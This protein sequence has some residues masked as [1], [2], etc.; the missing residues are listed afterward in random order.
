MSNFTLLD[1]LRELPQQEAA[2]L[3][4]CSVPWISRLVNRQG[5]PGRE[6]LERAAEVWP[7]LDVTASEE[8]FLSPVELSSRRGR[9]LARLVLAVPEGQSIALGYLERLRSVAN[10]VLVAGRG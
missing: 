3:L 10:D 5:R 1:K 2:G 6:L 9:E 4:G 8:Q 7:G